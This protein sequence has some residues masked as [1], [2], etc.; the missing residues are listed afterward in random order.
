MK[1]GFF[2]KDAIVEKSIRVTIN[3]K[4][5]SSIEIKNNNFEAILPNY[6]DRCFIK[7]YFDK[8]SLIF[9]LNNL[10]KI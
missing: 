3:N 1:L 10:A 8:K 7:I 4:K 6:E 2:N 9:F 5:Y